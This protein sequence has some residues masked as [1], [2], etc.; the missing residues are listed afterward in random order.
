MA[1]YLKFTLEDG[2]EVYLEAVDVSKSTSGLI[3]S[4]REAAES[5]K[6]ASF[7]QSFRSVR[8]MASAMLSE[9][10]QGVDEVPEEVSINFGLK[11]SAEIGSLVVARG[12]MEAN[13][14]IN[15]RWRKKTTAE[16]PAAPEDEGEKAGGA[17][18]AKKKDD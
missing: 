16:E 2:S 11:A 6:T 15:I 14:N 17:K 4:T 8:G 18:T 10:T 12:G 13:Y 9:L 5:A 3:P 7:E 1:S